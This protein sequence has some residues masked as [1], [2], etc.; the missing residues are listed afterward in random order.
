[1]EDYKKLYE[2]AVNK[3]KS[4]I[5]DKKKQGLTNCLFEGDLNE[6]FPQL[7][8]SENEII[9]KEIIDFIKAIINK[10]AISSAKE[11]KWIAWLEKQDPKK[12]EEELEKAYKCADEVQYKK[13]YEDAKR[14]FEEQGERKWSDEDEKILNGLISS[15]ARIGANTRTD[16]T[17]I[18]Y[19]FSREIEWLKSLKPQSHWRPTNEQMDAL[20][21]L[22]NVGSVSYCGQQNILISLYNDLKKL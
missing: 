10:S 19:T 13:G 21:I 4:I 7:M 20:K 16:S 18:N 8:E 9:R 5:A 22:N 12:H 15:L 11:E 2:D 6:I 3:I 17:S 1:M 14:E